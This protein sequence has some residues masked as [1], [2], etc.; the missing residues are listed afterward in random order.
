MPLSPAPEARED[1]Q[2]GEEKPSA[3][4]VVHPTRSRMP[5]IASK[6]ITASAAKCLRT[7][8][9]GVSKQIELA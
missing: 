9:N 2:P 7:G 8:V 1:M 6:E 5:M 3:K 4:K